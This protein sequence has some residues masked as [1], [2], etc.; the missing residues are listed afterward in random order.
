MKLK[1]EW[2][3][4]T[5]GEDYKKWRPGDIVLLEAQTGTGKTEFIKTKLIDY[6]SL[7][8]EMLFVCNRTN[9]KRQLKIALLNKYGKEIPIDKESN[10][11]D[12]D[13]LDKITK[14]NN[15]MITSYHAIQKSLLNEMYGGKPWSLDTFD[16]IILDECHY[17][18][19]DGSFNNKCRLAYQKLIKQYQPQAIKIF[20][21]ATMEELRKPILNNA[22]KIVDGK[23]YQYTTGIDY[24]YL[25]VKYFDNDINII[26]NTIK[27]DVS[28]EKWLIFVSKKEDAKYIMSQ[29]EEDQCSI[30][31]SGTKSKE[32]DSIINNSCF[33]KKVLICTKAMDN[34]INIDDKK[35]TNIVI[36]TWDKV[37]FI[38]MLGRKRININN[39]QLVNLYIPKR[40]KKSFSTKKKLC[41]DLLSEI[42]LLEKCENTFN[43]K[44][45]N[46]LDEIGYL[47]QLFYRSKDTGKWTINI[48]GFARLKKDKDYYIQM[49]KR[50]DSE[51]EF[52][53]IKQQ[54][55]WLGLPD[56]FDESNLIED[57]ISNEEKETLEQYL[58]SIVGKVMLQAKDRTELIEKIGLVD[59]NH[60]NTKK[61]NIK[62]LKNINTLN[63]YLT[64]IESN[65]IIKEFPT[66]RIVDN[67]KKNYK[68]AWKVRR[69][70]DDSSESEGDLSNVS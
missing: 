61:G 21:S 36:M 50:F 55:E 56:T 47:N 31:I 70:T 45:D 6:M 5:I 10:T 40:F 4:D 60:S 66:S 54:L 29:L 68:Q 49:E 35:L 3:S 67:K 59:P 58:D 57:T 19:T 46:D 27:N 8:Q 37:T 64:E 20:I 23:P 65:F 25:N 15:I 69:L 30:I 53:F 62:L 63:S 39:S 11:T 12:W 28:D 52:A 26:I 34:G 13:R 42:D 43:K 24:S 1:L 17:I 7:G 18:L 51:G 41:N 2:V 38:Q 22:N 9:L 48:I 14:I 33:E 44:Y 32:L 16:Y